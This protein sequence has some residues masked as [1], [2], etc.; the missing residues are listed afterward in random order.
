MVGL[1]SKQKCR[2]AV[3][4]KLNCVQVLWRKWVTVWQKQQ[5][6]CCA[7]CHA[8]FHQEQGRTVLYVVYNLT[9]LGNNVWQT[10]KFVVHQ[11]QVGCR[12]GSIG[13]T[14]NGDCAVTFAHGQDVVYAVA[15]HGNCVALRLHCLDKYCFLLGSYAS[16]HGVVVGNVPHLFIRQTF[17]RDVLFCTG[18]AHLLSNYRHGK[19][20]VARDNFYLNVVFHKPLDDLWRIGTDCV[21]E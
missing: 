13:T 3:Y 7:N 1:Q 11:H 19:W 21:L 14:T 18:N 20:I 2:Y 10:A 5:Q 6:D 12:F 16:K 9:A 17:Q 4:K 8:G 15:R